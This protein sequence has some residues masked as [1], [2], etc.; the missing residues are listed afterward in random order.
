M[1][2]FQIPTVCWGLSLSR[3]VEFSW[4]VL[5]ATGGADDDDDDDEDDDEDDD[6]EDDSEEDE[7]TEEEEGEE[8]KKKWIPAQLVTEKQQKRS[9]TN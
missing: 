1:V 2:G 7:D 6:D 4:F 8:E 9:H 3:K 5:Q